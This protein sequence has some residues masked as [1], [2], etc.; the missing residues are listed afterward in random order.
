MNAREARVLSAAN[1]SGP[2][3]QPYVDEINARI[4]QA[5][6]NGQYEIRDPHLGH[7]R[8]ATTVTLSDAERRALVT[9][10]GG[11]GYVWKEYPDPDPGHP[12]SRPFTILSW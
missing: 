10:Y 8:G 11:L 1:Q 7:R 3:I 2:V 6:T 12:C 5:A 9:H 4:R